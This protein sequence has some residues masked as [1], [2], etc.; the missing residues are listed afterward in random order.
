MD[1]SK[2]FLYKCLQIVSLFLHGSTAASHEKDSLEYLI[3]KLDRGLR[4][5]QNIAAHIYTSDLKYLSLMVGVYSQ[6]LFF[7]Y[8][9]RHKGLALLIHNMKASGF[10]PLLD[11]LQE[12]RS[13]K[14]LQASFQ[15]FKENLETAKR[16][17]YTMPFDPKCN[18][19]NTVLKML[20]D[21]LNKSMNKPG[22]IATTME[23]EKAGFTSDPENFILA[24][25]G[26]LSISDLDMFLN[27]SNITFKKL[28]F[29]QILFAENSETF[30]LGKMANHISN[31][32]FEIRSLGSYKH[33]KGRIFT[34]GA[35]YYTLMI[36]SLRLWQEAH[37]EQEDFFVIMKMMRSLLIYADE[38]LENPNVTRTDNL[39]KLEKMTFSDIKKLQL[40]QLKYQHAENWSGTLKPFNDALYKQVFDFV[41]EQRFLQLSKG[42]WCFREDPVLAFQQNRKPKAAFLFLSPNTGSVY[43]KDFDFKLDRVPK[44]DSDVSVTDLSQVVRF[45]SVPLQS[46][47]AAD[48][49]IDRQINLESRVFYEK[50]S[51]ISK[52]NRVVLAFYTDTKEASFVWSD[53]LKMHA[54]QDTDLSPDTRRQIDTLYQLRKNFQLLNL[55]DVSHDATEPPVEYD[56]TELLS[57]TEKFHYT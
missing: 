45:S 43:H 20:L 55:Q 36:C 38:M 28:F 39:S 16:F 27:D 51:L 19:H 22:K 2:S 54:N 35:L 11:N 56:E 48:G 42:S 24:N 13:L 23:Y 1:R 33:L 12:D 3:V 17:L 41:K 26:L 4:V 34:T 10:L 7:G 37:A 50:I 6:V 44:M 31:V 40:H 8:S 57:I 53:G 25:Y 15:D 5:L 49:T 30:P 52:A 46:S 32:I 47:R 14:E 21:T 9:F 18:G 29:Q